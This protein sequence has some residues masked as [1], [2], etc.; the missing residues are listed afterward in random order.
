MKNFDPRKLAEIALEIGAVKINAESP[1]QWASGYQMPVY[2]DNRLLLGNAGHRREIGEGLRRILI[3]NHIQADTVA[4]VA[5]AG[6]PHAVTLAN[7]LNLPLVYVRG[8]PKAHGLENQIEGFLGQN[9]ETVVVEDVIS[10]GGS[11]LRAIETLRSAGAV[12]KHCL[13]IF[14]YGFR[15]AA[16]DFAKAKCRLHSLLTFQTLLTY[17]ADS[18]VITEAQKE[19]LT[20]WYASPFNWG[21]NHGFPRAK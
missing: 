6:I 12:V 18:K 9:Q 7:M 17:A 2:N 5:T 16:E 4:G 20:A 15:K 11:A 3:S 1:F 14:D 8:A 13:C 19:I 21:E 10:T